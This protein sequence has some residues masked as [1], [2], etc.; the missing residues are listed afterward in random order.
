[1][2]L[3]G[4]VFFDARLYSDLLLQSCYIALQSYGWWHWSRVRGHGTG[5][6]A[7][8]RLLHVSRLAAWGWLGVASAVLVLTG[9]LGG[10]MARWTD[11][12]FPYWDASA[13]AL[14]LVAQSLQA[15]KVLESWI[16]FITANAIFIALYAAKGLYATIVLFAVL[17]A[18]AVLGYFRW[19]EAYHR[20]SHSIGGS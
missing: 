5:A 3:Y 12:S 1:M 13:T 10:A 6:I 15:L 14:S 16:V 17:T 7:P 9:A 20:H 2:A 19:R 18:M 4:F 8:R 11:A